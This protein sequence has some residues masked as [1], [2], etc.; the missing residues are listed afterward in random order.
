MSAAKDPT[1]PSL[2]PCHIIAGPLGVGK[3]TAIIDYVRRH[4]DRERVAVLVNDFGDVGL[5]GAIIGGA[6]GTGYD[7]KTQIVSIPGGCICCI[8]ADGL[9]QGLAQVAELADIDRIMIE[10]SGLAMPHQIIDLLRQLA[11]IHP[12]Q[13]RPVILLMDASKFHSG[14]TS[15]VP[16]FRNMIDA[17]D[18][19]V[20]NR[21]DLVKHDEVEKIRAWAQELDPP[22]LRFIATHH[23]H[24]PDE[25]FE[26]TA[27][28]TLDAAPLDHD[29]DVV[30]GQSG[31]RVWDANVVFDH[32][33]LVEAIASLVENQPLLRLKSI[34]NTTKGWQRIEFARGQL[35]RQT[36]GYR[37]DNRIEW[38]TQTPAAQAMQRWVESLMG[39]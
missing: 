1:G 27:E 34:F 7:S 37:R 19:L 13:L 6:I 26:M 29:H 16:Y 39:G 20:A 8:A 35:D 3:T 17:A 15:E 33:K 32:D 11:E 14:W 25:L 18:I 2:L 23:G 5:D 31:G 12:L 30:A 24:I 9:V 4:A 36:T 22:K 38:I 28:L 21:T 10:P